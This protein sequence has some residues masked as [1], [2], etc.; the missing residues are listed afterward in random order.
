[1]PSAAGSVNSAPFPRLQGAL[2]PIRHPYNHTQ[3]PCLKQFR[4]PLCCCSREAPSAFGASALAALIALSG[5]H[6]ACLPIKTSNHR[7][8]RIRETHSAVGLIW[9]VC[10]KLLPYLVFIVHIAMYFAPA[11]P[12][13]VNA[14]DVSAAM[15]A[16]QARSSML[17]STAASST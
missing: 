12:Q 17:K 9:R 8:T 14:L 6:A 13:P 15:E 7:L 11:A 16:P 4:L 2:T 5:K 10:P 1:M 3:T